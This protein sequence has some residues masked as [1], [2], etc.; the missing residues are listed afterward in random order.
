MITQKDLEIKINTSVAAGTSAA[1]FRE[2]KTQIRELNETALEFGDKFP[3][4]AKKAQQ[5]AARLADRL[6]DA[7]EGLADLK[8]EPLERIRASVARLQEG[9]M[10]MDL[11]KITQS[12]KNLGAAVTSAGGIF[13]LLIGAIVLIIENFDTLKN[14]GGMVGA[15]FTTIGE[16]VEGL[17]NMFITLADVIGLVDKEM[18]DQ[19]LT[20]KK[21]KESKEQLTQAT[22]LFNDEQ[23]RELEL[24]RAKGASNRE[25][26]EA[27]K[28]F[29][30]QRLEDDRKL[31]ESQKTLTE[32]SR[33]DRLDQIANERAAAKALGIDKM[34]QQSYFK[35][36]QKVTFNAKAEDQSL[37]N[38]QKVTKEQEKQGQLTDKELDDLRFKLQLIDAE[39]SATKEVTKERTKGT[40]KE[41]DDEYEF[42]LALERAREKQYKVEEDRVKI[43]EYDISLD[44]ELIDGTN[45]LDSA[46]NDLLET[47]LK[48]SQ[49]EEAYRKLG[50]A[51]DDMASKFNAGGDLIAE[52]LMGS[53]SNVR[54][55]ITDT[56]EVF[57]QSSG[58][59]GDNIMGIAESV[60]SSASSLISSFSSI[61]NASVTQDIQRSK[62]QTDE[63]LNDLQLQLDAGTITEKEFNQKKYEIQLEQF[64]KESELKKQAFE[65]N[66]AIQIVQAIILSTQAALAAFTQGNIAGGPVVGGIFAGIAA[67]FGAI[68][69]GLIA[70]Q[71]YPGD[72]AAPSRPSASTAV[73]SGN[74]GGTQPNAVAMA[75]IGGRLTTTNREEEM[76][77][78]VLEKDITS[79]QGRTAQIKNR[80]RR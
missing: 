13:A 33:Q 11:G 34:D 16:V 28:R 69:V 12:F 71:Q 74:L 60:L 64:R 2:L 22:K 20:E 38:K 5:E 25:I 57:K 54:K 21:A 17:K 46:T 23:D 55:S 72:G 15:I 65:Q 9:F 66:K 80:S 43:K 41:K 32:Q 45:E 79:A 68:Q 42:L 14:S 52:A 10:N 44:Q 77:V 39:L 24:M 75:D 76:R 70:S 3:E 73:P 78:Y 35:L 67:A 7:K 36:P 51:F 18:I 48:L 26:L 30:L 29:I 63:R 8:G 40:K 27:Q 1:T 37:G 4:A 6:D 50:S 58:E 53:F 47:T 61:M 49:Q 19:M 56:I 62:R 31:R 59:M